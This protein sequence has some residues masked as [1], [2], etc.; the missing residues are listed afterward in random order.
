MQHS[1]RFPV[2]AFGEI[3][4]QANESYTSI[5]VLCKFRVATTSFSYIFRLL[6]SSLSKG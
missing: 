2:D 6:D 4:A 1:K 5:F 3:S